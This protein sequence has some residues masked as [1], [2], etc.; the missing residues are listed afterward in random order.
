MERVTGEGES[1]GRSLRSRAR[2]GRSQSARTHG[3]TVRDAAHS[4]QGESLYASIAMIFPAPVIANR[5]PG[6]P[7]DNVAPIGS[8]RL[9]VHRDEPI[10]GT[11]G[12][13]RQNDVRVEVKNPVLS[14]D[15]VERPLNQ[16]RL[17]ERPVAPVLFGEQVADRHFLADAGVS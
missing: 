3:G 7:A 2:A 6:I 14:P 12:S 5:L 4:A 8:R 16:P 9:F 13:P 10:R 11:G 15:L 1:P 17:V